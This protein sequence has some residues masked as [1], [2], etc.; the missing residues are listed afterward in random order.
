MRFL[1]YNGIMRLFIAI[2]FNEEIKRELL[3]VQD[4]LKK[5]IKGNFTNSENFHLTLVFLGEYD[6][7]MQYQACLAIDSVKQNCFKV[8]LGRLGRFG[9]EDDGIIW[10][11]VTPRN[12]LDSLHKAICDALDK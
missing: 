9:K 8:R 1:L 5:K 4:E 2:Q 12:G 7:K 6:S 11:D 3:E 10:I